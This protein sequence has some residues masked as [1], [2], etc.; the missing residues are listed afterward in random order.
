MAN[1]NANDLTFLM[2]QMKT[3]S[4]KNSLPNQI[5]EGTHD[6]AHPRENIYINDTDSQPVNDLVLVN[7]E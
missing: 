6:D 4:S 5:E 3:H 1:A 2:N 7:D